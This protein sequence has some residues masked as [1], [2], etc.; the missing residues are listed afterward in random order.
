MGCTSKSA[1]PLVVIAYPEC[2]RLGTPSPCIC[3]RKSPGLYG[4]GV[5]CANA[6]KTL[7]APN[8]FPS[9]NAP[10]TARRQNAPRQSIS[11]R[12]CPRLGTPSK[13]SPLPIHLLPAM[14]P[15]RH[16]VKTLPAPNPSPSGNAPTR[17]AV[18][19]QSD[20]KS[21]RPRDETS[22]SGNSPIIS[23]LS[24][25]IMISTGASSETVTV[26]FL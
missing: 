8:P 26:W 15:T 4:H 3:V 21:Q 25:I 24:G 22:G 20:N 11:I 6:A 7:P 17:H 5:P 18:S 10:D 16:A 23:E 9:G 14:P 19:L 1:H 13:R 12:Q 2:T